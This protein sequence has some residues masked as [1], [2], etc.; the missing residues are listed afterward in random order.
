MT[1]FQDVPV[2]D[3]GT[4]VTFGELPNKNDPSETVTVA[5]A[6]GSRVATTSAQ[7]IGCN[8]PAAES[9][10]FENWSGQLG[11]WIQTL[12]GSRSE[13][14]STQFAGRVV[15]ETDAGEGGSDSC[16]QN[17]LPFHNSG[18]V[19]VN[20]GTIHPTAVWIVMRDNNTWSPDSVGYSEEEIQFL[21]KNQLVPCGYTAHQLLTMRC[22][23]E[24]DNF[25]PPYGS[26]NPLRNL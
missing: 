16:Y 10:K 4:T 5:I 11:N 14:G 13:N 17:G 22:N 26:P 1:V 3:D 18:F 24:G 20:G 23:F 15:L 25:P 2:S 21:R 9:T 19:W 6:S 7:V 12:S 8:L